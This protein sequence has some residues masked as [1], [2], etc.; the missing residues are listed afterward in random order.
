M[1][2][3]LFV[4]L[5]TIILLTLL[6]LRAPKLN[7]WLFSLTYKTL[8][9]DLKRYYEVKKI[10]LKVIME[11]MGKGEKEGSDNLVLLSNL[12]NEFTEFLSLLIKKVE[13]LQDRLLEF[14]SRIQFYSVNL[15][16]D[17][18]SQVLKSLKEKIR[19]IRGEIQNE[20]NQYNY[21]KSQ[22]KL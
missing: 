4:I 10:R 12:E 17:K 9:K 5:V 2:L 13:G 14:E 3:A 21:Y 11:L 19:E 20:T 1:K 22:L 16:S 18:D 8:K 7:L 15:W 6:V